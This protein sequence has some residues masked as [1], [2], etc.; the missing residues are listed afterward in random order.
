M[1]IGSIY[2]YNWSLNPKCKSI[3][4]LNE[5]T[6]ARVG[7]VLNYGGAQF[8]AVQENIAVCRIFKSAFDRLVGVT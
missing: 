6:I 7:H 3:E 8:R 5:S 2:L 1:C 4:A